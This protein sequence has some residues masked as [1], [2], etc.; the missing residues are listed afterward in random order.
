MDRMKKVFL[1]VFTLI[2]TL[3]GCQN[4]KIDVDFL[5]VASKIYVCDTAF[6]IV[7][8]MIVHEGKIIETG[9]ENELL[10]K[11]SPEEID[12]YDGFIYPGFI[13]AHAHFYGLGQMTSRVDL[14]GVKSLEAINDLL[15]NPNELSENQWIVA[16]GWDQNL[17]ENQEINHRFLNEKYPNHP[18]LLKRVDGH[19]AIAN[20]RALEIAGINEKKHINGGEIIIYKGALTGLLIDNAVD[21]VQKYVPLPSVSDH[22]AFLKKAQELCFQYGLTTVTDAGLDLGII[23]LIDSL[24]KAGTLDIRLYLMAN[25]TV[26][27]FD[28]FQKNGRISN[29]KLQVSSFKLYA[30]GALGSRGAKLKEDYCDHDGHNGLWVTEMNVLDSLCKKVSTLGFQVNTHCIGDSANRLMLELYGKYLKGTNDLRWRIEHAQVVSSEDQYLFKKYSVIP[31]VQ[32][33]HAVSD[34][35]WAGKR[36]CD[37]RLSGAYAYQNLLD[38]ADYICLGTDAPVEAINPIATFMAAVFGYQPSEGNFDNIGKTISAKNALFGMTLWAAKASWMDDR[39]GSLEKDK[40]ADFVV[41]D[42]DLTTLKSAQ[43]VQI[44]HT[45]LAGNHRF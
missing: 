30:D 33:V 3:I 4:K 37:H 21:S 42:K 9:S 19:A 36:L 20:K 11:Y 26:E 15:P 32:P 38:N 41:L 25:P 22:I 1:S 28:F 12:R 14:T 24:Q 27:N 5:V 43:K 34:L 17:W 10:K 13:D 8:A 2:L 35:P 45:F 44:L 18:V 23:Q 7:E 6:S 29:E 39:V 31:S 16:R 40:F